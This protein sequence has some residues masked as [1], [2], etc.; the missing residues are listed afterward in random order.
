MDK[1][2]KTLGAIF[3][4]YLFAPQLLSTKL[5]LSALKWVSL[6]K[7]RHGFITETSLAFF[8]Y[9]LFIYVVCLCICVSLPAIKFHYADFTQAQAR[10]CISLRCLTNGVIMII[11]FRS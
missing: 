3:C 4:P 9:Q 2:A 11:T 10:I 6:F 8:Y 1:Q 5:P 7:M